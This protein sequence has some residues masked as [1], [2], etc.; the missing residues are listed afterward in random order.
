MKESINTE[1]IAFQKSPSGDL[2][3]KNTT[4]FNNITQPKSPLG[5][6]GVFK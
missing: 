3:V 6:L 4:Q 2:G 1:N 5:D